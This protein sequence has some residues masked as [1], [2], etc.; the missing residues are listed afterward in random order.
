MLVCHFVCTF[1]PTDERSSFLKELRELI[2]GPLLSPQR[3]PNYNTFNFLN[4]G[5]QSDLSLPLPT[6]KRKQKFQM[7]CFKILKTS[8]TISMQK[9][10]QSLFICVVT[11][12]LRLLL[13]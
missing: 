9:Y 1:S 11:V 5:N 7:T 6:T 2:T 8:L 10:Y 12:S 13:L 4:A 3:E